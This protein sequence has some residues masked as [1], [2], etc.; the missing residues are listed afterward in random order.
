MFKRLKRNSGARSVFFTSVSQYLCA[1]EKL[2]A[3]VSDTAR[4][5]KATR[6]SS[7]HMLLYITHGSK[8]HK[9]TMSI[10]YTTRIEDKS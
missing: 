4:E 3:R 6:L 9:S 2:Q 5:L 1:D 7:S 10:Q 8:F